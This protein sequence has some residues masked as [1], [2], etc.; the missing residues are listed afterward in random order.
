MSITREIRNRKH[1]KP[2]RTFVELAAMLGLKPQQIAP[3]M[4]SEGAPKPDIVM[5]HTNGKVTR[6]YEPIAFIK[7]YKERK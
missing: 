2:L 1:R 7:W 4:A 3:L 5:Q 6:Y